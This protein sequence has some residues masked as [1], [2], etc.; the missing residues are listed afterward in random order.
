MRP[1]IIGILAAM[2]FAVTFILNQSMQGS[3]GHW[4]PYSTTLRFP[5][6]LQVAPSW[7]LAFRRRLGPHWSSAP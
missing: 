3:G 6:M 4:I 1:I 5:L 2:F 7:I